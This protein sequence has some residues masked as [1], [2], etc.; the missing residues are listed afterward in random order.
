MPGN[1]YHCHCEEGR[2]P[3]VAIACRDIAQSHQRRL[4][5][6]FGLR[7]DIITCGWVRGI[8]HG[9][10]RQVVGGVMTPPYD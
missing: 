5:Q 6:P 2:S 4:P 10:N 8:R 7:N 1:N 9:I 3:D